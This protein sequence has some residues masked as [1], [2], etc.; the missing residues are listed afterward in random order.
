MKAVQL[1][2]NIYKIGLNTSGDILF[3]GLWPI[4]DGVSI[5]AYAVKGEKIALIDSMENLADLPSHYEAE[6]ESIGITADKV[7]YLIVNHM[8]PDHSGW[9]GH[10][11]KKNPAIKIYCTAKTV[12]L[13][14]NFYNIDESMAV[15]VKTGD[16]LSLGDGK[17]LV[18]F[19]APNVHWPETMMTYERHSGILF[20]C[21][22]FGSY[23]AVDD[24]ASFDDKLSEERLRFYESEALRYYANIIA[25]FSSFVL[26]AIDAVS[27]LDI[28]MI[29]PSHGIVWRNKPIHIIDCYKKFAE[30]A[31]TG[32]EEAITL[33]WGSMYGN[34]EKSIETIRAAALKAGIKLYE[35]RVPQHKSGFILADVWRSKGLIFA[36]PTYEYKMFPPIAHEIDVMKRKHMVNK[37]V[38]R[39]GSFGWVGGAE[40][41]FRAATED[42]KWTIDESIEWPGMP[43]ADTKAKIEAAVIRLADEIRKELKR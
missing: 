35:H 33:V 14:K 2:E 27:G 32:G 31:V 9:I 39:I 6:L 24:D 10:Y 36:M 1:S 29:A 43:T 8:E 19:E 16:T 13:L 30:Y 25:S 11:V 4:P 38:L 17:E 3:E 5:N 12:P 41:E 26:K 42:A 37:K 28:K 18:F 15:A 22:A 21:D 23:G 40:R 20:S 34:T 7:D